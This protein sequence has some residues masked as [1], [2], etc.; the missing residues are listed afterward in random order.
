M[1]KLE[2]TIKF[3]LYVFLIILSCHASYAVEE[4]KLAKIQIKNFFEN[5]ITLEANFIQV[6]PS[7]NVSKGKVYLD[8]PGKLRI[9]YEK[10]KNLLITC[11][12]FWIVIQDRE[13]KTTNNI[14][15][16]NSPFALLLENT[17]FLNNQNIKTEYNIEAGIISLKLKSQNKDNQES[18]VLEFSENPFSLKKWV[19]QDSLGENTTVLIQNAKYNNKLSHLLFFP[20]DFPEPTN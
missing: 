19:I 5:L 7:G 3:F 1:K 4:N 16:K 10:P 8:L 2:I 13:S 18:L 6:S 9:D 17:S 11:K 15:V 14:P 20:I 12:G